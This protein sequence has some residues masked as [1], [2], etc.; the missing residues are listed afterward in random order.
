MLEALLPLGP[1]VLRVQVDAYPGPAAPVHGIA[2]Q[3]LD[4]VQGLAPAA[5]QGPKALALQDDLVAA[6]LGKVNPH[7]GGAVHVLQKA[8]EEGLDGRGLL[9]VHLLA[10]GNRR[11]LLKGL[12]PGGGTFFFLRAFLLLPG[13]TLPALGALPFFR[14]GGPGLGGLFPDGLRLGGGR[15]GKDFLFRLRAVV[16]ADFRRA[17]AEAQEAGLGPLQHLHGHVVPVQVQL[18]QG[19]GNGLVLVFARDI[20]IVSHNG[21]HLYVSS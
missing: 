18:G 1:V 7:P 2:G 13:E 20:N 10:Q 8:L 21:F 19:L 11:L 12:R 14:G 15:R 6:L 17:G 3:L 16:H 4:R 9:I 5:D